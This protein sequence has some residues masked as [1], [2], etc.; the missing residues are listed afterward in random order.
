[1]LVREGKLLE[2]EVSPGLRPQDAAGLGTA[3]G[4]WE[5]SLHGLFYGIEDERKDAAKRWLQAYRGNLQG[6][7]S[8]YEV[9]VK[10]KEGT[11]PTFVVRNSEGVA[12]T[13][14]EA[15]V[16]Q[17]PTELQDFL[18][19]LKLFLDDESGNASAWIYQS[20]PDSN[21]SWRGHAAARIH[22]APANVDLQLQSQ[23][24]ADLKEQIGQM[25]KQL[26]DLQ[27]AIE[28]LKKE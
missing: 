1:V 4:A 9:D 27:K 5:N 15:T 2:L 12:T 8:G 23:D 25:Q 18:K 11:S 20:T 14:D 16:L 7:P 6:P 22:Y 10:L 28:G 17:F 24:T 26:A 19:R 13:V 21:P 3:E